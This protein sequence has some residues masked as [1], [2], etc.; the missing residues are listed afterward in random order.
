MSSI[1]GL[2]VHGML[3]VSERNVTDVYILGNPQATLLK[4]TVKGLAACYGKRSPVTALT[5]GG[6][7]LW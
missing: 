7:H 2:T 4:P 5:V 3:N 6:K 1:S